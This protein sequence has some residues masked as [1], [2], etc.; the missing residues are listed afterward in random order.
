MTK[1]VQK[2]DFSLELLRYTIIQ[3]KTKTY[4]DPKCL[5]LAQSFVPAFVPFGL[6]HQ[7][8][9]AKIELF[10]KKRNIKD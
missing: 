2:W 10:I 6:F 7:L 4:I 9:I 8:E 1:I 3:L 5:F